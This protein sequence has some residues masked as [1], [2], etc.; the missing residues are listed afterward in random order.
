MK[1]LKFAFYF[2]IL[3]FVL[4]LSGLF[5]GE[6][7]NVCYK[8]YYFIPLGE[9]CIEYSL[10]E[11][12]MK[13]E[14]YLKTNTFA[15]IL[16]KIDDRGFSTIESEKFEFHFYQKEGRYIR[17]HFYSYDN[18]SI[19]Y[20]IVK[21]KKNNNSVKKGIFSQEMLLDPYLYTLNIQ[22][23]FNKRY[24]LF[25]DEKIYDIPIEIRGNEKNKVVELKP[26]IKTSGILVPKGDWT[27]YIDDNFVFTDIFVE[28]TIGKAKLK[29]LKMD[30]NKEVIGKMCKILKY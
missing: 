2:L 4:P 5:A 10:E 16:K 19:D 23:G 24:K 30:G 11:N 27:F 22:C 21:Y 20:E 29:L 13:I 3:I 6:K 17:D 12:Y 8:A 1:N 26:K 18:D 14:S 15:S 28:F 25:Y 7:L 9:A